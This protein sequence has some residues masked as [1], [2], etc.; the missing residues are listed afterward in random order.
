MP[1]TIQSTPYRWPFDGDLRRENTA[2]LVIDMQTDFCGRGGYVDLMGYDLSAVR[3][4]IGPIQRVL[5]SMRERG[6]S[7]AATTSA[8]R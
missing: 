7:S 4:C 8:L 3:A 6:G 1:I 2:L 5:G